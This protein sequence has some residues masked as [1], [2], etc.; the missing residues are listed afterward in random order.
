MLTADERRAGLGR[1]A[2]A[3]GYSEKMV[4]WQF[5]VWVSDQIQSADF[6]AFGRPQPEPHD[7]TTSAIAGIQLSNGDIDPAIAIATAIAAPVAAIAGN[8]FIDIWSVGVG[9]RHERLHQLPYSDVETI[10]SELARQLGPRNLT[11][12][13]EGIYQPALFP[14]DVKAL[15]E[16][17][18]KKSAGGLISLVENTAAFLGSSQQPN[19]PLAKKEEVTRISRLLVGAMAALMVSD[20]VLIDRDQNPDRILSRAEQR[21]SNYFSWTQ[22]LVEAE[23]NELLEA[24]QRLGQDVSYAGLDPRVVASVYESAI[25]D[26]A[27]KADFGVFYTPPELAKR[28]LMQIPIEEI[29][30]DDR[31]V[32]DP[33]CGSGT[34][35]LAAYDRLRGI[36]P[37]D[38]DLIEAH[39]DSG[40]RLAGFDID[41]LAVEVARLALLLNAMPATNGW[42]IE[43]RDALGSQGFSPASVVV[44]NPPWRDIRSD[45]GKRAQLADRFIEKMLQLVAPSGFLA[46]VVPGSWLASGTSRQ[47]RSRFAEECSLFEIWRLPQDTFPG[48]DSDVAVLFARRDRPAGQYVFRRVRKSSG[49]QARFLN[50]GDPGD[51]VYV[52]NSGSRL[53]SD[54]WLHGPLDRYRSKLAQHVTLG[55]VA[56]LGK[57]PVP[58]PP[59]SKRGGAGPFHWLP[60]L[61]GTKAFVQPSESLLTP[62]KYPDEFNWR[63]DD[64]SQYLL[65]KLMVSGV[66]NPDI[67]WRIKVV[68]DLS[69]GIIPR[70]SAIAVIPHQAEDVYSLLA[71]LGSSFASCWVDT[72]AP[73]RSISVALLRS[74]PI[75]SMK[76]TGWKSLARQGE[77][78]VKMAER[79][80]LDSQALVALDREVLECY[81]L[82]ANAHRALARYFAGVPAPEGGVRYT[83]GND[84]RSEGRAEEG[85]DATRSFGTILDLKGDRIKVW[86]A[87]VTK[88][89]GEWMPMPPSFPGSQLYPGATFDVI[90]HGDDITGGC[91]SLQS[92]SYLELDHLV[93]EQSA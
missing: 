63:N 83:L 38:L 1:F 29:P 68:P 61:R 46:T 85:L 47:S 44:S 71:I 22:E 37:L 52:A 8:D 24:I 66:R 27:K 36:A 25:L 78:I 20:K 56:D 80:T 84:G 72:L 28:I 93:V 13:K 40:R 3:L 2:S 59:V 41:P 11:A 70:D 32:L 31:Q 60:T 51:E 77:A 58:T 69:G 30:P 73:G 23:H 39:H 87:D 21:F 50:D 76:G 62:I 42:K 9:G 67:A 75:P 15:L 82:P 34:F 90:L 49:W 19:T 43:Q 6:V 65:P 4:R 16:E 18:R 81:S 55:T 53:R 64:G 17:A 5:P 33:A 48:A 79:E 14:S 86:I 35:L 12:A 7:Q 26:T 45:Q 54:S 57:G 91:F 10:P 89:E 88:D 92:E 74:L